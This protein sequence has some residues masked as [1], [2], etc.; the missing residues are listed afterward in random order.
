MSSFLDIE[1][2]SKEMSQLIRSG[3]FYHPC[4]GEKLHHGN[5]PYKNITTFIFKKRTKI[6]KKNS[7]IDRI[8]LGFFKKNKTPSY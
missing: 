7:V 3:V 2:I 6:K 8:V 4:V 5:T 1:A